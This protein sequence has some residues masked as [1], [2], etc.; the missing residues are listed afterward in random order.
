MAACGASL[1]LL[2]PPQAARAEDRPRTETLN[3]IPEASG[4]AGEFGLDIGSFVG[5]VG[6]HTSTDM[7]VVSPELWGWVALAEHISVSLQWPVAFGSV[8]AGGV[9]S[10]TAF[11]SGNP[12]AIGWFILNTGELRLHVGAGLALPLASIPDAEPATVNAAALIY[13]A[14]LHM[15]GWWNAWL[16]SPDTLTLLIPARVE[17]RVLEG[18]F[19]GAEFAAAVGF[20]TAEDDRGTD[21][22]LQLSLEVRHRKG[23]VDAGAALRGVL[24]PTR[25]GDGQQ[26]SFEPFLRLTFGDAFASLRFTLNIDPPAGFSFESGGLWGLFLGGGY[27]L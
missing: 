8:A 25:E 6:G 3:E 24:I 12:T 15:R 13:A 4:P 20:P 26:F 17:A 10:V 22:G 18:L 23:A 14:S 27:S 11:H 5:T 1:W 19:L 7:V 9:D 2:L 21:L 16:H